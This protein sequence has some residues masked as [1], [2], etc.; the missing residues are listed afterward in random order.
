M[1]TYDVQSERLSGTVGAEHFDV[2]AVSGGGRGSKVRPEG[3]ETLRSW[4]VGTKEDEARG[5]RGGPIPPGFYVCCYLQS[6]PPFGECIFLEQT[7]TSLIVRSPESAIGI[8][9]RD[10]DG[11]YIHGQGPK[12]SDGCIVPMIE[13][14]RK[15]LNKAVK[16]NPGTPLR[17]I[18]PYVPVDVG[19]P[20]RAFA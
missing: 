18:N 16:A 2:R 14:E 13:S 5:V 1:L 9:L 11:F 17:V 19:R 4:L 7:L 10:R 6:H 8:A 3:Q 20:G 15:R 12:G